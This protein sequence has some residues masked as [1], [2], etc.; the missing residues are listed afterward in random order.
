MGKTKQALI[1]WADGI[2]LIRMAFGAL[3]LYQGLILIPQA[4]SIGMLLPFANEELLEVLTFSLPVISAIGGMLLILGLMTR[5]TALLFCISFLL[6]AFVIGTGDVLAGDLISALLAMLSMTFFFT[7]GGRFS[8]DYVLFLNR[9][10]QHE[11]E[12][13]NRFG[14]Y[15]SR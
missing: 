15:V 13:L 14:R 5:I 2:A 12:S 4:R 1:S 11:R 8:I 7:G 3:L 10:A 9:R 6:S